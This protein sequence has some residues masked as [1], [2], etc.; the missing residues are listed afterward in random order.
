LPTVLRRGSLLRVFYQQVRSGAV[1]LQ[2]VPVAVE[3]VTSSCPSTTPAAGIH[4]PAPH[5]QQPLS[6]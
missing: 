2:V 5:L 4:L 1:R 3:L 6:N